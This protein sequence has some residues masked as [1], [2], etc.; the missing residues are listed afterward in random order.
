MQAWRMS[1]VV[2]VGLLAG[3]AEASA[4][5]PDP[6]QDIDCSVVAFYFQGLAEHQ[7]APADQRHATGAVFKWYS[8]RI[9]TVAKQEGADRVLS[10]A[11]PLLEAVKRDP[12]SM[13]DE[14]LACTERAV[15][16]GL[17]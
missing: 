9:Q 14:L 17:R 11:G 7:G 1:I 15:K 2:L 4:A 16:E 3:C 5:T 10:Q 12:R 8:A 6:S 13:G